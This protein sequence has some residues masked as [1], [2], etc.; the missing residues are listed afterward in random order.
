MRLLFI[1]G[2]GETPHIFEQIAPHLPGE[3]VFIHNLDLLSSQP[4][5]SPTLTKYAQQLIEHQRI[6]PADV[7]IGHS[8]GGWIALAIKHLIGCRIVQIAS[9]TD[10]LKVIL[11]VKNPAV[12]YWLIRRGWYLNRFTKRLL[13]RLGYRNK[14]SA[15]IFSEV[16]QN[17]IDSPTDYVIS[18]LQLILNPLDAPLNLQPDLR[19]HSTKDTIIRFPDQDVITVSGDHFNLF[20]H[21]EEVV[22]AINRFLTVTD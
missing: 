3:K 4:N 9:W 11:P 10:P 7:I 5:V 17:L 12:I 1:P 19:I 18:Q 2:F 21:P 16:F 14:P 22:A 13:L 8:M 20:T 15:S 6:T